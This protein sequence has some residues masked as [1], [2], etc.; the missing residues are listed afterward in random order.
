MEHFRVSS[1]SVIV[2]W[3]PQHQTIVWSAE[4]RYYIPVLAAARG[5]DGEGRSR[6]PRSSAPNP[7]PSGAQ[8]GARAARASPAQ[9]PLPPENKSEQPQ[10]C[11]GHTTRTMLLFLFSCPG[12]ASRSRCKRKRQPRRPVS[13]AE[14]TAAA[15]RFLGETSHVKAN[16]SP[17]LSTFS[18]FKRESSKR[19]SLGR[20]GH[21]PSVCPAWSLCLAAVDPSELVVLLKHKGHAVKEPL[22]PGRRGGE[23]M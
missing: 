18:C 20:R 19:N 7:G 17:F 13:C 21:K 14:R 11:A 5:W 23:L 6:V 12:R 4:N 3:W 15:Q 8:R 22:P 16:H 9:K 10:R 1:S 2:A